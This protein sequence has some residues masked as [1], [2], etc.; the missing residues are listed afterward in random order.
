MFVL[1]SARGVGLGGQGE[2]PGQGPKP[3][4]RFDEDQGSRVRTAWKPGCWLSFTC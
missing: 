4:D 3:A 1:P 2:P